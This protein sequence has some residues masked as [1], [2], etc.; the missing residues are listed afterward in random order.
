MEINIKPEEIDKY[1]KQAI[2]E[3]SIG[4]IINDSANKFM[5]EILTHKY[6]SPV[7]HIIQIIVR[8]LLKAELNKPENILIIKNE[9]DRQFNEKILTRII[10]KTVNNFNLNFSEN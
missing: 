1:V 8:D 2:I 10:E 3:S 7:K 5:D 6:D 4:K 9:F